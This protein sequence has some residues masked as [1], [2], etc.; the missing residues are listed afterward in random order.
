MMESLTTSRPAAQEREAVVDVAEGRYPT[1]R[2]W[3][4]KREC[5]Q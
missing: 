4:E 5:H 2:R 1:L 3:D